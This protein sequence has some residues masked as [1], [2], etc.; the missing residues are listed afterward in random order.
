[1]AKK[2]SYVVTLDMKYKIM[3]QPTTFI[4]YCKY[5]SITDGDTTHYDVTMTT[6]LFHITFTG[7][8]HINYMTVLFNHRNKLFTNKHRYSSEI[9]KIE[10]VNT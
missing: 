3:T 5:M 1:M 8:F 10:Y 2:Y 4:I 6:H 9:P 7:K